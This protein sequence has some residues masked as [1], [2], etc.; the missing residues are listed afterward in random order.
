MTEAHAPIGLLIVDD[1]PDLAEVLAL[2]LCERAGMRLV[3]TLR[4]AD[5]VLEAVERERPDVVLIDLGMAGRPPLDAVREASE[6]HPSTRFVVYSGYDDSRTV[7]QAV[8]AGAWGFVSKHRDIDVVVS[9]I[10]RV[11]A[12]ELVLDRG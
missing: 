11:A 12:G 5:G 6:R 2:T 4:S 8:D 10:R 1:N 7:D 9:V 3:G